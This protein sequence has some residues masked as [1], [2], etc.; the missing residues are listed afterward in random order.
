MKLTREQLHELLRTILA[1][2]P[3]EIDCEEFLARVG[4]YFESLDK[5]QELTQ[6]LRE[7]AQHL[8]VCREC[9]EEFEALLD[10][11]SKP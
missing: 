7:V 10:L 9:S 3:T 11:H 1:T 2:E 4:A 6:E 8:K 5:S